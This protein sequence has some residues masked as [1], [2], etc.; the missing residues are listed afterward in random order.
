MWSHISWS[1]DIKNYYLQASSLDTYRDNNRTWTQILKY[2]DITFNLHFQFKNSIDMD[3][4]HY[5]CFPLYLETCRHGSGIGTFP[6]VYS[7]A[8]MFLGGRWERQWTKFVWKN[9]CN[10]GKKWG[11]KADR[12]FM[13][14]LVKQIYLVLCNGAKIN[15]TWTPQRI[16]LSW[17]VSLYQS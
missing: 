7:W 14:V 3:F 11:E 13:V 2:H 12:S 10:G 16:I 5:S 4:F 6:N 9:Y 8:S 15:V 1:L 17:T